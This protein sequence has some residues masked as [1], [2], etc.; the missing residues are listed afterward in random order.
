MVMRS[1]R[2]LDVSLCFAI[3]LCLEELL[4]LPREAGVMGLQAG[5]RCMC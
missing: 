4:F 3:F 1:H 5:Y 2:C